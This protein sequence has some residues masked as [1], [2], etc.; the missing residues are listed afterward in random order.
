MG[1]VGIQGYLNPSQAGIMS[2]DQYTYDPLPG[3]FRSFLYCLA[4]CLGLASIFRVRTV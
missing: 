1:W 2:G 4:S 3:R